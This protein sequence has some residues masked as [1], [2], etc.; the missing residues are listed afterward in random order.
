MRDFSVSGGNCSE[1]VDSL[2][3]APGFMI[4]LGLNSLI[5]VFI[6]PF[7]VGFVYMMHKAARGISVEF[8]D[9]FI[10]FKQNF[11]Q[12]V[13]F[14][15]VFYI[16]LTFGAL[17]CLIGMFFVLPFFFTGIPIILFENNT[18]G[19]ALRKSF[20]TGSKNY[21]TLLGV[22]FIASI[23]SMAGLLLCGVGIIATAP[24][25]YAALYSAYIAFKGV[26]RV[27]H[28]QGNM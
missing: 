13:L 27:Q 7:F 6:A 15:I 8:A 12:Y 23:L 1:F 10:G 17:F 28:L 3:G 24:F 19:E 16:A 26:P 18:A 9:L 5:G 4:S 14:I 21:G 22:G 11:I 2:I 25:F 20:E